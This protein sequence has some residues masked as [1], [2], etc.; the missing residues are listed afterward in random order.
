MEWRLCVE[1]QIVSEKSIDFVVDL[2]LEESK[3]WSP[4]V[5]F[6]PEL[7]DR[8]RPFEADDGL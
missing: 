7:Q 1:E 5:F 2:E 8:S 3:I 4:Q 6:K